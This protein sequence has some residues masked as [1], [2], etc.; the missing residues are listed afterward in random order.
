MAKQLIKTGVLVF[1][2]LL[3][4]TTSGCIQ[5]EDIPFRKEYFISGRLV[6]SCDNPSPI[7]N[8]LVILET[9]H[10]VKL[11]CEP[12][13]KVVARAYT[14]NNGY[15]TLKYEQ[16]NC[17]PLLKVAIEDPNGHPT[18]NHALVTYLKGKENTLLGDVQLEPKIIYNYVI[19]TNRPYT[20]H[21]TL[22]YNIERLNGGRDS[23]YAYISGP[24]TDGQVLST[25]SESAQRQLH[26][27]DVALNNNRY[28]YEYYWRLKNSAGATIKSATD[29]IIFRN[30]VLYTITINLSQ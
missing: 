30:C 26:H 9:D 27:G 18:Q 15:F 17:I 16:Q 4:F 14:D 12:D 1:T 25:Y 24:F 21:D 6:K 23:S 8:K 10:S 11:F 28:D 22:Y 19:K 5:P 3:L 2:I 7:A 13:Y 29:K 20:Q